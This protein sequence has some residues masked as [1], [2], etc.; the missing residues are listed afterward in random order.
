MEF[1]SPRRPELFGSSV[2]P[3]AGH[4]PVLKL[5]KRRSLICFSPPSRVL[6]KMPF[7]CSPALEP[8]AND[9]SFTLP[10]WIWNRSM[11]LN[12]SRNACVRMAL[13]LG[14]RMSSARFTLTSVSSLEGRP[15]A[16]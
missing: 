12:W 11:K 7:T 9:W 6:A 2:P 16:R 15:V 14:R 5:R 13:P 3:S 10:D 8:A 1:P 4:S